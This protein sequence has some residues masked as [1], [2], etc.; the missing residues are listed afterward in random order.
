ME[1]QMHCCFKSLLN[2]PK[3]EWT[4][5]SCEN[6]RFKAQFHIPCRITNNPANKTN[7]YLIEALNRVEFKPNY[8]SN[9]YKMPKRTSLPVSSLYE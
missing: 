8:F 9:R 3:K 1:Q 6:S 5:V 7:Y 4:I 2:H